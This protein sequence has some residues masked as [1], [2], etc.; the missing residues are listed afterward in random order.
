MSNRVGKPSNYLRKFQGGEASQYPQ[1]NCLPNLADLQER[2]PPWAE[3]N[4]KADQ[5]AQAGLR[6][7]R[8]PDGG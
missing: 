6:N 2:G 1:R 3:E 4:E 5:E 8:M 7:G